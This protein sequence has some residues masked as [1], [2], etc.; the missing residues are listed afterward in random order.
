MFAWAIGHPKE[1]KKLFDK[2]P[3]AEKVFALVG[4]ELEKRW[5]EE[6]R[7]VFK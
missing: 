2:Q 5:I 1:A 6:L 4:K 7:K 3:E